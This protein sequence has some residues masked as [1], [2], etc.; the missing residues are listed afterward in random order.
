LAGPVD[1]LATLLRRGKSKGWTTNTALAALIYPYFEHLVWKQFQHHLQAGEFDLVHRL[2]PLSPTAPSPLA[3][4]CH[5]I[6]VPFLLGPLNGGVPWPRAFDSA[7]RAEREWLSY[8][9]GLYKLL[10]GHRSTLR[11]ASAILIGSQDTLRQVPRKYLW[12]THYVPENAIDPERFTLPRTRKPGKPLRC[13]FLG[14]LVPYKGADML[15][16]AAAPLLRSGTITLDILGDGPQMPQLREFVRA[17]GLENAVRLPGWVPHTQVQDYLAPCDLFTFPSIRE[18]GGAVVLEAMALGL[19][20]VVVNYG[21]PAELVTPDTGFL[22]PLGTRRQ[23]VESLRQTLAQCAEHPEQLE[24]K[25]R[26]AMQRVRA[27]FTW[28]A[29]ARQVLSIY[30]QLL[31]PGLEPQ[32]PQRAQR[33][34]REWKDVLLSPRR[35]HGRDARGTD[36][37]NSTTGVPPV[38]AALDQRMPP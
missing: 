15:L 25:S 12:K 20:P 28:D 13:V 38:Q 36:G 10:P 16:E 6:G 34:E 3:R 21:G 4:K 26:A 14:R 17:H 9:R 5:R 7:R 8:V 2:T 31:Y 33:K 18:F 35:L 11:H 32:K 37:A 30:R 19:V 23:I 27:H 29:K 22:L 24:E 1:R